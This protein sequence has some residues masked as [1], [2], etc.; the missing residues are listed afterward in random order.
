MIFFV[1]SLF[2]FGFASL[3]YS[4]FKKNAIANP[5]EIDSYMKAAASGN[6]PD[7]VASSFSV[8]VNKKAAS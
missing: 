3:L 2:G 4:I 7:D 8:Y 6:L 1:I 5:E